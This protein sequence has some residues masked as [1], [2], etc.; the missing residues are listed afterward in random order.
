MRYISW[1]M[2]LLGMTSSKMA[3]IL[4]FSK[5]NR[6]SQKG[7]DMSRNASE[8]AKSYAFRAFLM[9]YSQ[10]GLKTGNYI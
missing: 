4:D 8:C 3:S 6:I 1:A 7:V 5:E 2:A 10:K 9:L